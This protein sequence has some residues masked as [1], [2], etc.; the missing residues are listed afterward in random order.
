MLMLLTTLLISA[1]AIEGRFSK[2]GTFPTLGECDD[3]GGTFVILKYSNN[4][5]RTEARARLQAGE[6]FEI[7]LDPRNDQWNRPTVP[8]G[9]TPIDYRDFDVT[10]SGKD[11]AS[12]WLKAG[13]DSWRSAKDNKLVICVPPGT[14]GTF[15][16][17]IEIDETGSLDPRADVSP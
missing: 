1:C 6:I 7:R 5:I 15:Y 14:D 8:G 12:S 16:Y 11:A 2:S 3:K 17:N 9:S 13:P 10:I 4:E